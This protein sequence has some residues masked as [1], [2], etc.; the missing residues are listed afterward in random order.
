MPRFDDIQ[1]SILIASASEQF[2]TLVRRSLSGFLMTDF[3]KSASAARRSVQERFFDMAVI[4]GP[5]PDESGIQLAIHITKQCRASVLLVVP[6]GNYED[7]LDQVTDFGILVI[8]KPSPRGR[9]DKAVRYLAAVQNQI[10]SLKNEIET[11]REKMEEN[12][13]VNRAKFWLVEKEHLTEDE[14]HRRIGK[15]AMDH[16]VSRKRIAQRILEEYED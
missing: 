1:H 11:L 6:S 8:P 2:D 7:V 3:R 10:R 15:Q 4:N 16:G 13:I 14:A 9:L 12:R 5:L